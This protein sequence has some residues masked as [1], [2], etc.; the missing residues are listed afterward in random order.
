MVVFGLQDSRQEMKFSKLRPGAC[1][2]R[3]KGPGNVPRAKTALD[4]V[5]EPT[6][7]RGM[8]TAQSWPGEGRQKGEGTVDR[9][10]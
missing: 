1:R 5:Y 10:G 4:V 8:A 9:W 3:G 2:E 6:G 7:K